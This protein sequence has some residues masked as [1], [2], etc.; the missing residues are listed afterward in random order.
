M[1]LGS[2]VIIR[3]VIEH[4]YFSVHCASQLSIHIILAEV[5][6]CTNSTKLCVCR[7]AKNVPIGFLYD[8]LY[9]CNLHIGN[10]LDSPVYEAGRPASKCRTGSNDKYP[11][12][13]GKNENY[14]YIYSRSSPLIR[15]GRRKK[16]IKH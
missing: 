2:H 7:L 13:C 9:I 11:G 5:Y 14:Y 6:I 4:Q 1:S 8:T 3:K 12:L 16:T 10:E 15:I